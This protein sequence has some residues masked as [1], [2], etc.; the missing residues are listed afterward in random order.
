LTCVGV[1]EVNETGDL[2]NDANLADS[3]ET[4]SNSRRKTNQIVFAN[5]DNFDTKCV[6]EN[7]MIVFRFS[8]VVQVSLAIRGGYVPEKSRITNNKTGILG[9][10]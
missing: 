2:V 9:P 7:G 6:L 4:V 10:N 1:D 3:S 5:R 8:L